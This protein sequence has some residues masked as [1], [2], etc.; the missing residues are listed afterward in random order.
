MGQHVP[1]LHREYYNLYCNLG[2]ENNQMWYMCIYNIIMITLLYVYNIYMLCIIPSSLFLCE[3]RDVLR[4]SCESFSPYVP[5][6]LLRVTS[7]SLSLPEHHFSG[8]L[9]SLRGS[10]MPSSLTLSPAGLGPAHICFLPIKTF[11][12]RMRR[13]SLQ[14]D[15]VQ[16]TLVH[17]SSLYPASKQ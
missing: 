11:S 15:R 16:K 13:N 3:V 12:L 10:A 8:F 6:L 4:V 2:T 14:Y 5:A 17:L 1:S 7:L 9:S